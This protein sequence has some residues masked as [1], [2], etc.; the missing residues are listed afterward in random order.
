MRKKLIFKPILEQ[1]NFHK[2]YSGRQF[3]GVSIKQE[4]YRYISYI[5]AF[6]LLNLGSN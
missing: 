5:F 1:M 3:F 4:V 6:P 2:F